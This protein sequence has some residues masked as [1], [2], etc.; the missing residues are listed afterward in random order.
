M[1]RDVQAHQSVGSDEHT[2]TQQIFN[3]F[4]LRTNLIWELHLLEAFWT[5]KGILF[6]YAKI[7]LY[8]LSILKDWKVYSIITKS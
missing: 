3:S 5:T 8:S 4:K 6:L 2:H 7:F 1:D